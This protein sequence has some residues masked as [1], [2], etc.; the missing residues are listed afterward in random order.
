MIA[1]FRREISRVIA[2]CRALDQLLGVY[3]RTEH[4]HFGGLFA[5]VRFVDEKCAAVRSPKASP[6]LFDL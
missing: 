3:L 1:R 4:F 5:E 6:K 2:I